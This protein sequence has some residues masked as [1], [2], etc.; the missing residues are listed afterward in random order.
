[1]GSCAYSRGIVPFSP[2]AFKASLQTSVFQ[3]DNLSLEIAMLRDTDVK[4]HLR[5][6]VPRFSSPSVDVAEMP[7]EAVDGEQGVLVPVTADVPQKVEKA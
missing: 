2:S 1:M 3:V 5:R 4:K 6:A 7:D